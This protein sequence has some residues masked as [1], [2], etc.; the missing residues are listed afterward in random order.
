MGA[1]RRRVS[2][3]SGVIENVDF[4]GFRTLRLIILYDL[5]PFRLFTDPT[6]LE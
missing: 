5:V 4:Q 3:D 2:N 1:P 6:D